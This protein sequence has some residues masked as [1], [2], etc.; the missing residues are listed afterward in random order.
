MTPE[1][2]AQQRIHTLFLIAVLLKG[3]DG[4]LEIGLGFLLMFTDTFSEVVFFLTRNELIEDP[5]NFFATHLRAFAS[6]SHEAFFIG[7][8]YLVA[9]GVLKAF[10]SGTLWRNY[11]WAYPAAMMFLAVFIVY[12][13]IRILQTGSIPLMCLALFD[14]IMLGLVAYEYKRWPHRA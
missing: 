8:L 9:H 13:L 12:E 3:L 6:Q 7:G 14:V 5:N 11:A 1:D 2:K 4:I 10:I